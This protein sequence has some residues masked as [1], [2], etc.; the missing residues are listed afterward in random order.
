[1]SH[2]GLGRVKTCC[3]GLTDRYLGEFG[4]SSSFWDF[5]LPAGHLSGCGPSSASCIASER[6]NEGNYA[7]IATMSGW[8]PMMFMTRVRL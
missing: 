1:M 2:M 8:T 7:L 3:K 4:R 5:A 6:V